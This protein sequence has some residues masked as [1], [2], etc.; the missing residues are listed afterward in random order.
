VRGLIQQGSLHVGERGA[1]ESQARGADFD[2]ANVARLGGGDRGDAVQKPD[3]RVGA[4]ADAD[5]LA[6]EQLADV[7][8]LTPPDDDLS[9]GRQRTNK[10]ETSIVIDKH[11]VNSRP[12]PHPT[13]V[14]AQQS[15]QHL[16]RV[17]L[18]HAETRQR[19][20]RELRLGQGEERR[21]R[22]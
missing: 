16:D 7:D 12:P 11:P 22:L 17:P 4:E 21:L 14:S 10:G 8:T 3:F 6:D 1:L 18:P 19:R 2:L 20:K 15:P 5:R 9:T 13:R